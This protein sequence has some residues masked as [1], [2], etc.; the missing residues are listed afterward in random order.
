MKKTVALFSLLLLLLLSACL[1]NTKSKPK[2]IINADTL[3]K[4]YD[5]QNDVAWVECYV[6]HKRFRGLVDNTS[7]TLFTDYNGLEDSS[8]NRYRLHSY[9]DAVSSTYDFSDILDV[10]FKDT[11]IAWQFNEGHALVLC[12][13][14]T[15]NYFCLIDTLG[16]IKYSIP[17][18]NKI[19]KFSDIEKI[20][21]YYNGN[22]T[23]YIYWD[24]N[25]VILS[26]YS[27]LITPVDTHW[28]VPVRG[29]YFA[30]Q[31]Q[32]QD[33]NTNCSTYHLIN[34]HG[35]IIEQHTIEDDRFSSDIKFYLSEKEYLLFLNEN[36][37]INIDRSGIYYAEETTEYHNINTGKTF[38]TTVPL[39]TIVQSN[40]DYYFRNFSYNSNRIIFCEVI[41]EKIS[42]GYGVETN[43]PIFNIFAIDE[44][45][46]QSL[47]YSHA[48]KQ[49][50]DLQMGDYLLAST[51]RFALFY[52]EDGV[53]LIDIENGTEKKVLS[54]YA[55]KH[56]PHAEHY[57]LTNNLIGARM[58]G[59]D[60][61]PYCTIVDFDGNVLL[62]LV[63]CKDLFSLPI[64]SVG[65][66]A[67]LVYYS[68]NDNTAIYL[69][70]GKIHQIDDWSAPN[71]ER[72]YKEFINIGNNYIRPNGDL[73][74]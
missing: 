33:F 9:F 1:S 58:Y 61:K 60:G 37:A 67:G 40:N 13:N 14:D 7:K 27:G 26:A 32:K 20:I 38:T 4:T 12:Q 39:Q 56:S 8:G 3:N 55:D 52:F 34:A 6:E 22:G 48:G 30:Y 43:A 74:F 28:C 17:L 72:C 68:L 70:S 63:K 73:L 64:E 5:F 11:Q 23:Y 31:T 36:I 35:N 53:Y 62:E 66:D 57:W 16:N 19:L 46:Q 2:A 25:E 51:D 59:A 44:D 47:V 69:N 41:Y 21:T 29:G 24:G 71:E 10:K 42:S 45:G 54:N 18:N 15:G 50:I 49:Y 65:D